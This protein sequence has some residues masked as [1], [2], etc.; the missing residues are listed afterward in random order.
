M[1]VVNFTG[2]NWRDIAARLHELADEIEEGS[3]GEVRS[4]AGV[5]EAG[6][7]VML[8]GYGDADTIRSHGLFGLAQSII[9]GG[10]GAE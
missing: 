7:E 5:I 10:F 6:D 9:T 2:K 8:I 3:H 1:E 4:F